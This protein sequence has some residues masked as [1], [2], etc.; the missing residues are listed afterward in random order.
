MFTFQV[1]RE[2]ESAGEIRVQV[3]EY[4]FETEADRDEF[5]RFLGD[6]GRRAYVL[7]SAAA[8]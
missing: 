7:D 6:E 4:R 3:Q 5:L 1:Y 2:A 8:E